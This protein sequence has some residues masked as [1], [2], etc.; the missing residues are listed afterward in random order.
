MEADDG[1]EF[2]ESKLGLGCKAAEAEA[3]GGGGC[4]A[5]CGADDSLCT[6]WPSSAALPEEEQT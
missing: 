3:A 2:G 6:Y 5:D 1:D 4:S